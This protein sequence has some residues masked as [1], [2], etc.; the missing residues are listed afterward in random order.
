MEEK[1]NEGKNKEKLWDKDKKKRRKELRVE[2]KLWSC[3][4]ICGRIWTMNAQIL[5]GLEKYK[6][7][8]R[9]FGDVRGNPEIVYF[10]GK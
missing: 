3:R 5:N 10:A 1:E 2:E 8:R 4:R 7:G 6:I 9:I